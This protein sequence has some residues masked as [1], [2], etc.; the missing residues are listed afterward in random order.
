MTIAPG[1]M[2]MARAAV[3]RACDCFCADAA[4]GH[5]DDAVQAGFVVGVVG[6]AQVG[7]HVFDFAAS[8]EALRADQPIGQAGLQEG[9]FQQAGLGVG[10]IH[11][12]ALA[13]L[14][15]LAGDQLRDG[16]YNEGSLG[17]IVGRFIIEEL[18][19]LSAFGE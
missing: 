16:I 3:N 17:I 7:D 9:F 5:V 10:A 2:P 19:A 4:C 15:L 12:G 8:V 11:D 13:R 1:V 18:L 6:Q 14:E